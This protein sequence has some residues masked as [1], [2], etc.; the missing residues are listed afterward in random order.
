MTLALSLSMAVSA[1]SHIG[2]EHARNANILSNDNKIPYKCCS[3][4]LSGTL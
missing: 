4:N 3:A 2:F 1:N